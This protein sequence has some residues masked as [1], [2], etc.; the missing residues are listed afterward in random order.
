MV[1]MEKRR[2]LQPV[3]AVL[4]IA[5]FGAML[6][7]QTVKEISPAQPTVREL[8]PAEKPFPFSLDAR[9]SVPLIEFRTSDQ[10]A[11]K[12]RDLVADAESSIGERA[13]L[14]GMEFNVGKW[15][16]EQVVCSAITNHVLLR[17]TRNNGTGDVSVFSASIPRDADGRVRII[18]IQ[19]RGY[20]LFSPAPIN[21]MAIAAF[22][23]IRTGEHFDAPPDWLATGLCYAAL[24]GGRPRA[25]PSPAPFDNPGSPSAT[26]P[27]MLI[28]SRGIFSIG[29]PPGESAGQRNSQGREDFHAL[30]EKA[31]TGAQAT[32][33][34]PSRF[35]TLTSRFESGTAS[36]AS[37]VYRPLPTAQRHTCAP[38]ESPPAPIDN[39][40]PDAACW[41]GCSP[42]AVP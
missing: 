17:F 8:T 29:Q 28:Q 33:D 35:A 27:R 24:T 1:S 37:P 30:L 21:A 4:S 14:L 23:R 39:P 7:A 25:A 16:Y 6:G 9:G 22:N 41:S 10:L 13:A 26:P 11:V 38:A 32:A 42:P 19:M 31:S 15:N 12:D 34:G 20:S 3:C 36:D 40:S 2:L 18:P 5:A